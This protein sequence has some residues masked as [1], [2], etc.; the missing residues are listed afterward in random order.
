MPNN[1]AIG[2]V[3]GGNR[4]SLQVQYVFAAAGS[5]AAAGQIRGIRSCVGT[6]DGVA[7]AVAEGKNNNLTG[8]AFGSAVVTG[9]IVIVTQVDGAASGVA[10]AVAVGLSNRVVGL[11]FGS[12]TAQHFVQFSGLAFGTSTAV[13]AADAESKFR[14]K[15]LFLGYESDGTS[16]T[17]PI[18]SVIG[19]TAA[20]AD[21]VTGDWREVLQAVLLRIDALRALLAE[22]RRL[23]QWRDDDDRELMAC[24]A[25]VDAALRETTPAA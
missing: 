5:A 22:L 24:R 10:S 1:L 20:E 7:T 13:G 9:R 11:A 12:S 23:E 4:L 2:V 16:I 18:A 19:L 6:T 8:T 15:D 14:P 25:R 3:A 17:I 21:T